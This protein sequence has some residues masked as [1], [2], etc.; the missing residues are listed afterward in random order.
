MG[1]ADHTVSPSPPPGTVS[2][3]TSTL[4][5]YVLLPNTGNEEVGTGGGGGNSYVQSHSRAQ[6]NAP[7]LIIRR[8]EFIGTS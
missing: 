8:Q 1:V 2:G 4:Y 6:L 7:I 5:N 3:A